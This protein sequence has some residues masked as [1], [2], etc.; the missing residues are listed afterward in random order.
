MEQARSSSKQKAT[1]KLLIFAV[2]LLIVFLFRNQILSTMGNYL[3]KESALVKADAIVVLGGGSYERGLHASELYHDGY[4]ELLICTGG[5]TPYSLQAIGKPMLEAQV[6]KSVLLNQ[7]V[8][9]EEII[10]LEGATSTFEEAQEIKQFAGSMALERIIIVSSKH[11][12]RRVSKV[13]EKAF[14]DEGIQL[15]Y[16]GAPSLSYEESQWWESEEGM[17]MVNNEYMK[18]LYYAFMH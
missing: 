17:I 3:I 1:R 18:L 9:Q 14:Q 5:N 12:T 13:F 2:F 8:S 7:S 11:H 6:S 4:A 10:C 15:I 16:S